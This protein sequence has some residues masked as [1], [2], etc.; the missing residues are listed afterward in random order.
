MWPQTVRLQNFEMSCRFL[1]F[2]DFFVGARAY[3]CNRL[4]RLKNLRYE[5]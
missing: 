5:N 1:I 3:A 2:A 4:K